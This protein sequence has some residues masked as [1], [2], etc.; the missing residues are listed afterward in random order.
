LAAH[1]HLAFDLGAESGRAILGVVNAGALTL[2]EMRRFDNR[3]SQLP[4]GWHWDLTGLFDE[5][6]QGLRAAGLWCDTNNVPLVSVGVDTWGVDFGL[7]DQDGNLLGNPN[8]Y[9][10]DRTQEPFQR[11]ID[12]LS[13]EE[14]Y[15]NTGIQL[16]PINSLFQLIACQEHDRSALKAADK[17][18][19]MPDLFHHLLSGSAC[20]ERTI[21]STSQMLD[22]RSGRWASG[23]LEKLGL[24]QHMLCPL[25]QPG[26]DLGPLLSEIAARAHVDPGVRVITPGSHDTASAVAAVPADPKTNWCFLSSGTWSL[27]G[28]ELDAPCIT[29]ASRDAPFTNELGVGNRVRFL[30]N[31][32]GLW[33]VQE[34]RRAFEKDGPT[35]SY[36]QLTHAAAAEQPLQ[37]I[38]DAR[39][40]QFALPGK[41]PEKLAAFAKATSQPVPKTQGQIIRCCLESLA[42]KY[43]HTLEQLER[44][45]GKSFDIIHIVGGGAHNAMLNQLTADA[46]GRTVVA[47]P[48]EAT[49]A[50]NILTQAMGCGHIADLDEIRSVV[51]ASFDPIVHAPKDTAPWD[52]AYERFYNLMTTAADHANPPN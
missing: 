40:P 49:A 6:I 31:I 51:A 25:V 5:M 24:P 11:T 12:T 42:M 23:L 4:T 30:Q 10:D 19:F 14:I 39:A 46:T 47:G 41:M 3:P 50:G 21:A 44:V 33:L 37:T 26:T 2:H 32:V 35:P 29:D 22:V 15:A 20:N 8:C 18:L 17:L 36:E 38:V 28:A 9:R 43:R 45:L 34:C 27:L 16:M 52:D 7:L 13:R 48:Y 1:A